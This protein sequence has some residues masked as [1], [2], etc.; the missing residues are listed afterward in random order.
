[1]FYLEYIRGYKDESL[2]CL[3]LL[4]KETHP[5]IITL[6]YDII[7]FSSMQIQSVLK[8]D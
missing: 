2:N 6:W 7:Y 1:M 4:L 3:N 5:Q 8:M